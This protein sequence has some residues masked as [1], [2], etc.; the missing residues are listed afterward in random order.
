[1][2]TLYL[3]LAALLAALIVA[4]ASLAAQ[5]LDYPTP[6]IPRNA[7]GSANLNAPA[8]RTASSRHNSRAPL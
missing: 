5:W 4:P 1:M 7:D 8:P 2:M 3:F 6:G